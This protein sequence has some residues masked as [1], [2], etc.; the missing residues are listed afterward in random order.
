M[1]NVV[2]DADFL[3]AFLKIEALDRVRDF[4]RAETLLL[5]PAVFREVAVTTLVSRLAGTDWLEVREVTEDM[6][7]LATAAS[8]GFG[9]LGAGERE[10]I[11][12]AYAVDGAVLLMND[13]VALRHASELGVQAVSIP[14]F[15]LLYRSLGGEAVAEVRGLVEALEERDHYG[16]SEEIRRRLLADRP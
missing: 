13:R 16:F 6:L 9:E 10:A 15:L 5:P 2:L 4:F 3:S 8:S 11:A 14:A 12:L 7:R 1:V